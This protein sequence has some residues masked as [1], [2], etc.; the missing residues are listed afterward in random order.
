MRNFLL[1]V[2]SLLVPLL[3]VSAQVGIQVKIKGIYYETMANATAKVIPASRYKTGASQP[4][5]SA[6]VIDSVIDVKG[7]QY[8]VVMIDDW[9]FDGCK[10]MQTV[11]IPPTVSY[12]GGYA[13]CDCENLR[14]ITLPNSV[15]SLGNCC[16][17]NCRRLQTAVMP[18]NPPVKVFADGTGKGP[19]YAGDSYFKNCN[20][21]RNIR[22]NSS[23][24]C[25]AYVYD[26]LAQMP[27][28]YSD[29]IPFAKDNLAYGL[30]SFSYFLYKKLNAKVAEWQKKG[31]F[32]STE[33]WRQRVTVAGRDKVVA[34]TLA[35]LYADYMMQY[36]DDEDNYRPS[37][38]AY[39]ADKEQYLVSFDKIGLTERVSVPRDEAKAFRDNWSKADIFPD[40]CISN[41]HIGL[42]GYFIKIN[43]MSYGMID[44]SREERDIMGKSMAVL[45]PLEVDIEGFAKSV[46]HEDGKQ[47][48]KEPVRQ[49]VSEHPMV[50]QTPDSSDAEMD[51]VDSDIPVGKKSNSH[52]FAVVIGN[53]NY[54]RV[55]HVEYAIND[56]TVFADYCQKTLGLPASNIRIYKDATYGTMLT[57]LDDISSIAAAYEGDINVIFYYA[58]HGIPGE[59]DRN[60]YLLPVDGDGQHTEVC[61]ST[62]RLYT[63]LNAL[64]ARSVAVFMDACFSGAQRGDGMLLAARGVALKVKEEKPQGNVVV[65]SA[66]TDDQ[67][68]FPLKEKRHGMFTYYLL[69]K[70]HDTKGSATL[71]EISDY[72]SREVKRQSVV[73]NRKSQT[74]TVVT[75]LESQKWRSIVLGK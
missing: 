37:L 64:R 3:T 20:I 21:L 70:L 43:G 53:E 49:S 68:A 28:K 16:F 61:L 25:P 5:G 27:K 35:G 55:A 18:D 23:K 19:L 60:A 57:A 30:S 54:M 63:T 33:Q 38:G 15:K 11:C 26:D 74:P 12:I 2:L 14:S 13:F 66:A 22:G 51:D 75:E 44:S 17:I 31:E 8:K 65:L 48:A 9:A 1:S 67:T 24:S 41:D 7:K 58:G 62:K 6:V 39:D 46:S 34:E 45:P 10:S 47:T 52:T 73:I 29:A 50:V 32:E 42:K 40:F 56:A 59:T 36:S 69:K 4:S 72:V 71:G